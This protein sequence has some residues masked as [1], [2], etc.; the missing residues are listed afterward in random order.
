[1]H[2]GLITRPRA[3]LRSAGA[4]CLSPPPLSPPSSLP[5]S[6]ATFHSPQRAA[7]CSLSA[8]RGARTKAGAARAPAVCAAGANTRNADDAEE[9]SD[10]GVASDGDEG[11][12]ELSDEEGGIEEEAY[13]EEEEEG[14]G[15]LGVTTAGTDW[16]AKA[17]E[18]VE[19][20]LGGGDADLALYSFRAVP[21][22]KRLDV[23]I[24]KLTGECAMAR[25]EGD[26]GR[27]V[28]KGAISHLTV[29]A[30]LYSLGAFRPVWI[31][32]SGRGG[33]LRAGPGRGA[34]SS[35]GRGSRRRDRN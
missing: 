30:L 10:G 14:S 23:R 35:P 4:T 5:A 17:L 7:P 31:A 21:S 15:G 13:D 6:F 2:A 25:K 8:S 12:E 20:L 3:S 26:R 34:G 27:V 28:F 33:H 1:M 24:D 9:D 19:G 32:L 18:V 16:G 22:T 11:E 29:L